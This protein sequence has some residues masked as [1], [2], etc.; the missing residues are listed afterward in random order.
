MEF[1][2]KQRIVSERAY[3][4]GIKKSGYFFTTSVV[5]DL[6]Q[7]KGSTNMGIGNISFIHRPLKHYSFS[8]LTI[9]KNLKTKYKN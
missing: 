7:L 6:I 3:C 4:H 5:H 8:N 1:D 9:S 2:V